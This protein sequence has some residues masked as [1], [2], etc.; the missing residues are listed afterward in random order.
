MRL[1]IQFAKQESFANR[2]LLDERVLV[3]VVSKQISVSVVIEK[4]L[5]TLIDVPERKKTYN[6]L[7]VRPH[8]FG[9]DVAF[10][11]VAMVD[12]PRFVAHVLRVDNAV[13]AGKVV[14]SRAVGHIFT[15]L[16]DL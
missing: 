15:D 2:L 10:S 4:E 5:L 7:A 1:L 12:E 8:N 9:M 3:F 13:R 16:L 14:E 6:V 11:L